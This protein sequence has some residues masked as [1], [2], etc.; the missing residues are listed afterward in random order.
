MHMRDEQDRCLAGET[1]SL[2]TGADLEKMRLDGMRPENFESGPNDDPDD[3]NVDMDPDEGLASPDPGKIENW[4]TANASRFHIGLP[5]SWAR[6]S[7]A[8]TASTCSRT[9]TSGSGFSPLTTYACSNP[10]HRSS[11]RARPRGVNSG[12]WRRWP[13]APWERSNILAG[14]AVAFLA[15]AVMRLTRGGG[16]SHSQA[17]TWL[18]I[19]GIF[20]VVSAW[21]WWRA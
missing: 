3:P 9:A 19:A 8:S 15:A 18:L 7:R 12:C 4:W 2:I 6:L 11:T 21:L 1:F 20:G 13:E 5:T 16:L 10:A 14:L 17:R